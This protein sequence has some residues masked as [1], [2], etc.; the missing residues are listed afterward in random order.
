MTHRDI[1][2]HPISQAR[3]R[4]PAPGC[5]QG[6]QLG[7]DCPLLWVTR[8][9]HGLVRIAEVIVEFERKRLGVGMTAAGTARPR[10][11]IVSLVPIEEDER[12]T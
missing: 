9:V 5:L 1:K 8:E 6:P 3:T 7:D 2:Q 12:G 11:S 4:S 10:T